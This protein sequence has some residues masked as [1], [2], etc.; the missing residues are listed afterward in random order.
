MR[1]GEGVKHRL[2]TAL[3]LTHVSLSA[4]AAQIAGTVDFT[5]NPSLTGSEVRT[6]AVQ[7]DGNI[8]I[9]GTFT[10]VNG[11]PRV[12]IARLLASGAVE[13]L[14]T[15]NSGGGANGEVACVAVQPDGKI[16]IAGSFTVVNGQAR[17]RIA[18]LN[19][20][21]T[22][23]ST[24]TFNPGTGASS[25]IRGL[26]VQADG[27]I[28]MAGLFTTVNGQSRN[29]IAR[30]NA[31]GTLESLAT[32]NPGT[33]ANGEIATLA[34][35]ADGKILLGGVFNTINGQPRTFIARLHANGSVE[36][37]ATFNAGIGANDYVTA[38][39]L[40]ADQKIVIGGIFTTM[41]GQPRN[42]IA[43]L[44][45]DGTV[46]DIA[47]FNPGSG[48][49]NPVRVLAI[50]ADGKILL[51]GRFT[52][53]NSQ[54]RSRIARLNADG[55]LE[56][57]ATFDPGTGA[58]ADVACLAI[59]P[60]GKIL[61]GGVF[62]DIDDQTHTYIARLANDPAPQS[63]AIRSSAQV[64]WTRDG[65]AP[66]VEEVTFELSTS[67]GQNWTVLGAATRMAGGWERTGLSLPASGQVRARGRTTGG[68]HNG[69]SG[70]VET[71]AAFNLAPEIAVE[72]PL[73][74]NLADG[75]SRSFGGVAVGASASLTFIIKNTGI[76][77]LTGL[78]IALD[79]ADAA[80]FTITT[81]PAAPVIGP[82]G[83]T[84]FTVRF[85]PT[86]SGA[87]I[88]ALHIANNDSDE[89]PFDIILTGMG[90]NTP[91]VITSCATNQ[92]LS[93]NAS[94]QAAL[95]D[96]TGQVVATDA[97]DA[98][99]TRTQIPP[100]GTLLGL[101]D[102]SVT[103]IVTDSGSLTNACTFNMAVEDRKA[104]ALSI[105]HTGSALRVCWPLTCLSY[106][107]EESIDL[108]SA[109][110]WHSSSATVMT[111]NAN[112]YVQVE[113]TGRKWFRLSR[114]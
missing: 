4:A 33:G 73:H 89:N 34:M 107:L 74:T 69:S 85:V 43:R 110:N 42:R 38:V 66:E 88:A 6:M 106:T 99:L 40:Q 63:L 44:N 65:A 91:P 57:L 98:N 5:F 13:S 49:D 7:P 113:V 51:G 14:S 11:Q 96:L 26:V 39:A 17:N 25:D 45:V 1:Y 87:K 29:R 23:E 19:P 105:R 58:H 24:A 77:S 37:T 59:E 102:H 86:N 108:S 64:Q 80:M 82:T 47:T 16:L 2:S 76:A 70:L 46:E 95:P 100:A 68:Y 35:Q 30:L 78:G 79:G 53:V 90:L 62:T 20:D 60:D 72:Q 31:D 84:P 22:V 104:V 3:W 41:N 71:V 52:N 61:V 55:T 114:L 18:R 28:L 112:Y 93:A 94:C 54:A 27:R 97:E 83:S 9:G 103:I 21:G 10:S 81:G 92:A 8:V 56:S 67:D 75:G 15:F 109:T 50:Q 111:E 48:A 101:G 36:S 32:F 12:R